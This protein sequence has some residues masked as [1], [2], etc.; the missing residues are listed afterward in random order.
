MSETTKDNKV[1]PADAANDSSFIEKQS[2]ESDGDSKY[3]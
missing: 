1:F 2:T 3:L